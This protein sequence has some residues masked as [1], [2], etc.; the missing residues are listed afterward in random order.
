MKICIPAEG[1]NG[2]DEKVS[3]HFGRA[4]AYALVDSETMEC[5]F[6][7]NKS[8]HFGG[9]GKPPEIIA[10]SGAEVVL[11]S[12]MGPRAMQMLT[13]KG[14]EIYCGI[15][16]TVRD[17]VEAFKKGYLTLASSDL[18]CKDHRH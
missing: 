18:A 1:K 11:T 3:L 16:G 9:T 13:E 4:P 14:V 5:E 17:S 8:E 15:S 12:G 2:L 7:V 10:E 6:I